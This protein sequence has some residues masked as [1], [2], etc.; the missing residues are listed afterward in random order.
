MQERQASV[1]FSLQ[2]PV[3]RSPVR[4][5]LRRYLDRWVAELIGSGQPIAIGLTAREALVAALAP[6]GDRHAGVL[7]ADLGL[8][9][10]SLSV[11]EI[12]RLSRDGAA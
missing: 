2:P 8:I 1:E 11:L 3:G 7:L 12:D 10:P 9:E 4:V 5:R 6:L